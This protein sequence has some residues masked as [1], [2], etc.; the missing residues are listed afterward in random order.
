MAK[1]KRKRAQQPPESPLS[2]FFR[3]NQK[4]V[5]RLA[6]TAGLVCVLAA[7]WFIAD[8]FGGAPTAFDEDGQEVNAGLI[9]WERGGGGSDRA[10]NFLLPDYDQQAVRLEDF[11]GKVVFLN[12]W[13]SWCGPCEREMPSIIRIAEQFPDDVVVLAVNRGESMGTATNWTRSRN[14]REDLPNFHWLLDSSEIVYRKF[15]DGNGMPQSYFID[16]GG[17]TRLGITRALE[18]DDMVASVERA[19]AFSTTLDNE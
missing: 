10:A 8:P 9:D 4:W 3:Q 17:V 11:S 7:I 15:R 18:F 2:H 19:L 5:R 12:F 6:I 16:Q 13:A 14:F 1:K